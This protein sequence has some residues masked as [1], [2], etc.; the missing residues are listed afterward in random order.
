MHFLC[1]LCHRQQ[2]NIQHQM[3][4]LKCG[5]RHGKNRLLEP[6]ARFERKIK[7]A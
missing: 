1:A 4:D 3:S 5:I 7:V 6:K 2:V